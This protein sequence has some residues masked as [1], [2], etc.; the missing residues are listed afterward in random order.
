M[1][2]LLLDKSLDLVVT[3]IQGIVV[4]LIV[5]FAVEKNAKKISAIQNQGKYGIK[6]F[7][8][9]GKLSKAESKHLFHDAS[10]I[11]LCFANGYN[12]FNEYIREIE[13]ALKNKAEVHVLLA[14][15]GSDF[16]KEINIIEKRLERGKNTVHDL[17]EVMML[18]S[19]HFGEHP[20]FRIRHYNTL[21]RYTII[22]GTFENKHMQAWF[23]VFLPP[24][25]A[26]DSKMF[27]AESNNEDDNIVS[28]FDDYFETIWNDDSLSYEA[29][30]GK[31]SS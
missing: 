17:E 11:R 13:F 27:Y 10:M 30:L 25:L 16:E 28:N 3:L 26:V 18:L 21:Y 15:P 5:Y 4:A 22:L 9:R 31:L 2:N 24:K 7:L 8:N 19:K 20:N 12:F 6:D 14:S 1:N 29:S 23:N